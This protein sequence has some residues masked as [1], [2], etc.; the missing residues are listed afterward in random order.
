MI[1]RDSVFNLFEGHTELQMWQ[2]ILD[3]MTSVDPRITCNTTIEAQ[4]SDPTATATFDF[5]I[6]NQYVVR[7]YRDNTN[8][9]PAYGIRIVIIV[10]GVIY[11]ITS[12]SY[13]WRYGYY[14]YDAKGGEN[15][16]LRL[17][18]MSD[19][20][21]ILLWMGLSWG[22]DYNILHRVFPP[23]CSTAYLKAPDNECY[24]SIYSYQASN[25]RADYILRGPFYRCSDGSTNFTV[26]PNV[27]PYS[28]TA[29]TL[30]YT[31]HCPIL[32]SST[33][34]ADFTEFVTCSTI[35]IG[36]SLV[37]SNGKPYIS[38]GDHTLLPLPN[39]E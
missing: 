31:Q 6:D 39:G 25:S 20:N 17:K 12:Y 36:T 23:S 24:A 33:Q 14:Y 38:I 30:A 2:F 3:F 18:I 34:V 19:T 32:S 28:E 21:Y 35:D 27:F 26:A 11:G 37:L 29:G 15:Y 7:M 4:F 22:D 13:S 1:T 5:N 9:A 16:H 10:N 8:N